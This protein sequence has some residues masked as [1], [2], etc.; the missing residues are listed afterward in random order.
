MLAGETAWTDVGQTAGGDAS[1]QA[2]AERGEL[3][4]SRAGEYYQ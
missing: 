2:G 3:L 1:P 4:P